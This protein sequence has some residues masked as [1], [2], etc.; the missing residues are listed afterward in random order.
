MRT[1]ENDIRVQV[2]VGLASQLGHD[3]EHKSY[4]ETPVSGKNVKLNDF[5]FE[6]SL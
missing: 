5:Q 2:N 1:K 4:I 6:G 3:I